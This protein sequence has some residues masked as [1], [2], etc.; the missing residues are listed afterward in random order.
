[1]TL[2][3]NRNTAVTVSGLQLPWLSNHH[4]VKEYSQVWKICNVDDITILTFFIFLFF[5]TPILLSF[6]SFS[7]LYFCLYLRRWGWGWGGRRTSAVLFWLCH[8]LPDCVLEGPVCL[9]PAHGILERVGVFHCF[10]CDH[11]SFDGCD[12]WPGQS[13]RLHHWPEGLSHRC[14]VCSPGNIRPWWV[15]FKLPTWYTVVVNTVL[16]RWFHWKSIK[17]NTLIQQGHKKVTVKISSNKSWNK[18]KY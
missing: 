4:D 7:F 11:R 12:W 13:L 1:M 10:Y 8:A 17:I 18:Q 3:W 5:P 15:F 6:L 14:G 2:C 9:R 16:K